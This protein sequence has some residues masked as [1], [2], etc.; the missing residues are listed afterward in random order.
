MCEH[1]DEANNAFLG[2]QLRELQTRQVGQQLG[3]VLTDNGSVAIDAIRNVL[4]SAD[5]DKLQELNQ[6]IHRLLHK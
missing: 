4:E 6:A 2:K 5:Y 3:R 1:L